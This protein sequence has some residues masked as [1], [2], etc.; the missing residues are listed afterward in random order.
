[1]QDGHQKFSHCLLFRPSYLIDFAPGIEV[2]GFLMEGIIEDAIHHLGQ[3]LGIDHKDQQRTKPQGIND[4]GHYRIR[5]IDIVFHHMEGIDA[6]DDARGDQDHHHQEPVEQSQNEIHAHGPPKIGEHQ[7]P[8]F[9]ETF[10]YPHFLGNHG[11]EGDPD[12]GRYE[13]LDDVLREH[14]QD[15]DKDK[16]HGHDDRPQ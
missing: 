9:P 3:T 7:P 5:H 11:K 15:R 12:P 16:Y 13:K 14:P 8:A 1:K 2:V 10:D 4:G 6:Q